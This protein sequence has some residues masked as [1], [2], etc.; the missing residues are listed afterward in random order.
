[1]IESLPDSSGV[2]IFKD[3]QNRVIYIGKA[4]SIKER[5]KSYLRDGQKDSKTKRLVEK[6]IHIETILTKNEKE[7]FLLENNLIKEHKPRY[8]I[9]LKDDKSYLSLKVTIHEPYPGLYVTRK[10]EDDGSMYF[11][12]YPNIGDIKDILKVIHTFYPVRR[13]KNTVFKKRK[14]ACIL[15]QMNRCLA[16][17]EKNVNENSYREIVLELVDFLS[18]KDKKILDNLEKEIEKAAREWRFEDA[19]ILK[20]RFEAIKKLTEKQHVHEHLG[21]NRDVWGFLEMSGELKA[22]VLIFRR[23][24]LI[25]KKTYKKSYAPSS[26]DSAISSIIFQFY[27]NHTVPEEII[28]SQDIEDRNYLEDFLK[29]NRNIKTKIKCPGSGNV[30]SFIALAVENLYE[31]GE[32]GLDVTFKKVLN[33]KRSPVRIEAYDISHIHGKHPTGVMVVFENFKPKKE[34]YRVFHIRDATPMDDTSS[35]MEVL[36]RRLKDENIKP[37]PELIIIDGGK[38]QLSSALRV[39]NEMNLHID[40]IGI[41]KGLRRDGMKDL[42]YVPKRKNPLLLPSFSPVLKTLVMIRDEAH[43][44]ALL[45]Q[46]KWKKKEAFKPTQ[47]V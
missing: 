3:G 39:L 42:I 40:T 32:D 45:S 43:R 25:S 6:I 7:A 16:P 29:E 46:R 11:G 34:G 24:V 12:P 38:A 4:K 22:V 17:C 31:K 37:M 20:E 21:K 26:I 2:Y 30:D 23:G 27:E 47:K 15:F 36:S 28:I 8:N 19:R 18:G 10:I 44:F 13:C 5:V 41:A 35:I 1:M 9:D 33:L 14:R